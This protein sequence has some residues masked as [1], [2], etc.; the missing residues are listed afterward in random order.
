M[1]NFDL[2]K[3]LIVILGLVVLFI[4]TYLAIGSYNAKKPSG[5][6]AEVATVTLNYPDGKSVSVSSDNDPN[7]TIQLFSDIIANSSPAS[8]LPPELNGG[9][10]LLVSFSKSEVESSFK[11]YFST[12]SSSCYYT[13]PDGKIF[14][15]APSNAK[16]FLGTSLSVY[17]YKTATPPVLT[18]EGGQEISATSIEW[19]YLVSGGTYQQ[20]P[21]SGNENGTIT[22]DVGNAFKFEF[23][24]APSDTNLKVYK[25]D[26]IMYDGAINEFTSELDRNTNL[27][28][29][30]SAKWNQTAN[31][32]YYGNA[33][34]TFNALVLA[35]AEFKLGEA[36]I[37]HGDIA[38]LSGI[39]ITDPANISLKIEPELAN[40]FK[41]TFFLDG[42]TAHALIP[43]SYDV[44][45]GEYK[46]TVRYGV[47]E[48]ILNL[49]VGN[50]RF[51]FD[52]APSKHP[53]S[54]A[55]ISTFY[56]DEDVQ[57]YNKLYSEICSS[58]ESLKYFSGSF[59]NYENAG[60]LTNNKSTIK[61][62]FSREQTLSDGRTVKHNGIDFEVKEGVDV[63]AMASGKVAYTG[64]CDVLGNFVVIDHG[65][66]LK[67]WYAH[68]SE[69]SVSAGDIVTTSQYIGKT[70]K[71]GFTI[72]NRIH[73]EFSLYNVPVAPFS[74]W[75]E[76]LVIAE[77]N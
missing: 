48:Q 35:P 51:G 59:I 1:K 5:D 54:D 70:G 75:D 40:G 43:F 26:T 38:V 46:I 77:F 30:I 8:S 9:E 10:F 69:I 29:V 60:T 6:I 32:D 63:P 52:K 65:Y 28:F 62:G 16:A 67:S 24:I 64:F 19:F 36:Q 44:P 2:K 22:Y 47:T 73:I 21:Y 12:D 33:T 71:T 25:D 57:S 11:F 7:A 58:A 42:N 4:P 68:L 55:L 34:Y 76:G 37:E 27:K 13:D 50:S 18:A 39:N 20:Y 66:G 31:C 3:L 53:A 15:I 61:L 49:T 45:N 72:E 56:T 23:S 41:P 17:L 14:K 74:L